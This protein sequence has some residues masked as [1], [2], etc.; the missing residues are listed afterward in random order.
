MATT[1]ADPAPPAAAAET[2]QSGPPASP[3]LPARHTAVTPGPRA[4]RLQELFASSLTHTLAKISWE[5]FASC[6]PTIA[7]NA[8]GTLKA[9]QRQMVDRLEEL[10]KVSILRRWWWGVVVGRPS[11]SEDWGLVFV[12]KRYGPREHG[13]WAFSPCGL[14]TDVYAT[15]Q[16][17]F[18]SVMENRAVVPK[19]NELESLVSDATRR[20]GTS[21]ASASPIPYVVQANHPIPNPIVWDAADRCA[22]SRPHTL[23][24]ESVLRAHMAPHLT[25]Q[26]SQLN[27]KLQNTQAQNETLFAEI[28]AQ[29]AE[30]EAL[31]AGLEGIISDVDAANGLLDDVVDELAQEAR[32]AEVEMAGT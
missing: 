22:P 14:V 29:R 26:Q 31:L 15:A 21:P 32:T 20:R 19:L 3:P 7:A 5:N 1:E 17:E 12:K 4:T 6:Y 30:I 9:V 10:C 27:A 25:S 18:K 11:G 23:P 24:A 16:K 2:Q 13:S 28:Q 8:P